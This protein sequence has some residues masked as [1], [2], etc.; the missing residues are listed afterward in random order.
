M[1]RAE[2]GVGFGRTKGEKRDRKRTDTEQRGEM[3]KDRD[4]GGEEAFSTCRPCW[5]CKARTEKTERSQR[6]PGTA[7]RI[8]K[9]EERTDRKRPNDPQSDAHDEM[10]RATKAPRTIQLAW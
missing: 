8:V 6:R 2:G 1:S 7:G 10:Q 3:G 5:I 9:G 4:E